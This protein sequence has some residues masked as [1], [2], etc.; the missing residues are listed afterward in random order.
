MEKDIIYRAQQGL[1]KM[2]NFFKKSDKQAEPQ[3]TAQ[4]QTDTTQQA[5]GN[6]GHAASQQAAAGQQSD[7]GVQ[8]AQPQQSE[9]PQQAANPNDNQESFNYIKFLEDIRPKIQDKLKNIVSK[10]KTYPDRFLFI[11]IKDEGIYTLA[12]KNNMAHAVNEYIANRTGESFKEVQLHH[13]NVEAGL[14]SVEINNTV[15]IAVGSGTPPPPPPGLATIS[16]LYESS[17][18]TLGVEQL[19]LDPQKQ[20]LWNIGWDRETQING[21]PRINHIAFFYKYPDQQDNSVFLVSRAHAHIKY[22]QGNY[23]LFVDAR[24]TRQAGKRTKIE[25]GDQIFELTDTNVGY[26]LK[27]GDIIRL[28][29]EYLLFT[30]K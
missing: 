11:Y 19:V 25:R 15:V 10:T 8:A 13:G 17:V 27:D 30:R 4:S 24:G 22:A 7:K 9:Q 3:P 1:E 26:P 6:E 5:A 12:S 21:R 20:Q 23:F 29:G 18:C 14:Q 2:K 16:M 28:N